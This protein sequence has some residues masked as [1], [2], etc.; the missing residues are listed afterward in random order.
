MYQIAI[1]SRLLPAAV[2]G[3]AAIAVTEENR[4]A[5]RVG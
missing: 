3:A 2:F 4:S 1:A 5:S